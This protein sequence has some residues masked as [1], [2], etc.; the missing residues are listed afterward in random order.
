MTWYG[1]RKAQFLLLA[2]A[3][4]IFPNIKYITLQ[5]TRL[6]L[7]V[8][9]TFLT[10]FAFPLIVSIIVNNDQ[11]DANILTY[12][13]IPNQ[14][15]MFRVMSSP[16]IRSTWLYLQLLIL[17]T[18]TAARWCHGWDGTAFHLIHDT[19]QQQYRWTISEAVNTV[20]CSWW[21]AKI[22]PETCSAD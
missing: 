6:N 3:T 10:T 13:F 9:I 7:Q 12:L 17:S 16:I 22:S 15:Y 14:R 19:S 5:R 1:I 2:N 11:Q 4:R 18:D 8:H 20:K 21:W